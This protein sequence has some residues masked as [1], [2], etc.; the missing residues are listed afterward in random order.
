MNIEQRTVG[1]VVILSVA[2]DITM[3]TNEATRVSDKVRSALQQG[4]CR[5]V[6][7]L[8]HVRY[9]DSSGLGDLVQAYTA[10]KN[11]GGAI[12]LI[13]VGKRLNDLLVMTKL[14]TVFDCYDRESDALA[15]FDP[16]ELPTPGNV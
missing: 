12:K 3:N 13:N 7:D 1:D 10:A 8:G 2:G 9:V 5:L 16:L 6:L 11:R 15:S 14:L 4:Q